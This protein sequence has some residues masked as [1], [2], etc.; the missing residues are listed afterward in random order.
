MLMSCRPSS[1]SGYRPTTRSC[2]IGSKS[3]SALADSNQSVG[4]GW[5]WMAICRL[6]NLCVDNSCMARDTSW[7]SLISYA[8][9]YAWLNS[10]L[11]SFWWDNNFLFY[12]FTC[13][14][15][16]LLD[17]H[18]YHCF[19]SAILCNILCSVDVKICVFSSW[20]VW[21]YLFLTFSVIE[22]C[23]KVMDHSVNQHRKLKISFYKSRSLVF[24]L[25]DRPFCFYAPILQYFTASARI[26]HSS[27][28]QTRLATR[29][30][31]L[32]SCVTSA[33]I[34]SSR[35]RSAGV[36]STSSRWAHDKQQWV[37]CHS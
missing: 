25:V 22:S 15:S 34:A 26:S 24:A 11:R 20:V 13:R 8:Q 1:T 32:R 19:F 5:R 12:V 10:F 4:L 28:C 31:C 2:L 9:R 18:G 33:W 35:R 36:S 6:P 29:L 3:R 14:L 37:Q 17:F 23:K 7:R 21:E 16:F 30:N 27:G